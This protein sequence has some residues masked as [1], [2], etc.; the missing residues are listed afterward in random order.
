MISVVGAWLYGRPQQITVDFQDRDRWAQ[1]LRAGRVV[2]I[3]RSQQALSERQVVAPKAGTRLDEPQPLRSIVGVKLNASELQRIHTLLLEQA[4]AA[5]AE[6]FRHQRT[7]GNATDKDEHLATEFLLKREAIEAAAFLGGFEQVK[8]VSVVSVEQ[9]PP[10]TKGESRWHTT[11]ARDGESSHATI[12]VY[13]NRTPEY[14]ELARAET[15]LGFGIQDSAAQEWNEK[16]IVDRIRIFE[17][18]RALMDRREEARAKQ[19]PSA[20]LIARINALTAK[21]RAQFPEDLIEVRGP[22]VWAIPRY[23]AR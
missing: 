18:V 4:R 15:D 23:K 8:Y 21:I 5:E 9:L 16:S 17:S 20:E 22:E 14:W 13:W 6:L 19:P 2:A 10:A 11:M 3:Q 1:E 12:A 7:R